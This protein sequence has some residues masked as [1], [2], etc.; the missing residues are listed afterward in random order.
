MV[1]ESFRINIHHRH[2]AHV[3]I[4]TDAA[5]DH[6]HQRLATDRARHRQH[7][8]R[9][10]SLQRAQHT[11]EVEPLLTLVR[12]SVG[13]LVGESLRLLQGLENA[14][15]SRAVRVSERRLGATPLV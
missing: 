13:E 15:Q 9:L 6:D 2:R 4:G 8:A 11:P 3:G 14:V 12:E 10:Q 5:R 7:P 1:A